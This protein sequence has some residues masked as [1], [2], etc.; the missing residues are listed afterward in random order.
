MEGLPEDERWVDPA[1]ELTSGQQSLLGEEQTTRERNYDSSGELG[2]APTFGSMDSTFDGLSAISDT[3]EENTIDVLTV[4]RRL[5]LLPALMEQNVKLRCLWEA[6]REKCKETEEKVVEGVLCQEESAKWERM[7]S[8]CLNFHK[9]KSLAELKGVIEREVAS[10]VDIKAAQL[11][12]GVDRISQEDRLVFETGHPYEEDSL[13]ILPLAS[14]LANSA[15]VNASIDKVNGVLRIQ[16]DPG[17]STKWIKSDPF[18]RYLVSELGEIVYYCMIDVLKDDTLNSVD[19]ALQECKSNL[20]KYVSR[21]ANQEASLK[22]YLE[23]V[24]VAYEST[25]KF[26][27]GILQ[28]GTIISDSF[29]VQEFST[30]MENILRQHLGFDVVRIEKKQPSNDSSMVVD[31]GSMFNDHRCLV[32]MPHTSGPMHS[33]EVDLAALVTRQSAQLISATCCAHNIKVQLDRKQSELELSLAD[34]EKQREDLVRAQSERRLEFSDMLLG[35][36][37]NCETLEDVEEFILSKGCIFF[38]GRIDIEFTEIQ[39]QTNDHVLPFPS[40]DRERYVVFKSKIPEDDDIHLVA[41]LCRAISCKLDLIGVSNNV[42][43]E[44][45]N[46]RAKYEEQIQ[47]SR[48]ISSNHVSGIKQLVKWKRLAKSLAGYTTDFAFSNVARLVSRTVVEYLVDFEKATTRVSLYILDVESKAVRIYCPDVFTGIEQQPLGVGL[49]GRVISSGVSAYMN[50]I[51]MIRKN[52]VLTPYDIEGVRVI[53]CVPVVTLEDFNNVDTFGAVEGVAR[54]VRGCIYVSSSNPDVCLEEDSIDALQLVAHHVAITLAYCEESSKIIAARDAEKQLL[55]SFEART[56]SM[57]GLVYQLAFADSIAAAKDIMVGSKIFQVRIEERNP[58]VDTDGWI[59]VANTCKLVLFRCTDP[60]VLDE[61]L[62]LISQVLS[63]ILRR[64]EFQDK[65]RASQTLLEGMTGMENTLKRSIGDWQHKHKLWQAAQRASKTILTTNQ[66]TD[67]FGSIFERTFDNVR[68]VYEKEVSRRLGD[69]FTDRQTVNKP[70]FAAT[71]INEE[72]VLVVETTQDGCVFNASEVELFEE[73]ALYL[74]KVLD[75]RKLFL[76]K[77]A[78]IRELGDAL[79]DDVRHRVRLGVDNF[80]FELISK[81]GVDGFQGNKISSAM[82]AQFS[83]MLHSCIYVSSKAQ[84]DDGIYVDIAGTDGGLLFRPKDD[85]FEKHVLEFIKP[86]LAVLF[87]INSLWVSLSSE[88][89]ERDLS[90]KQ[91]TSLVAQ[92]ELTMEEF[93]CDLENMSKIN[94]RLSSFFSGTKEELLVKSANTAA[95]I[96]NA[97]SAT[98]V[99][100]GHVPHQSLARVQEPIEQGLE[101]TLCSIFP[102]IRVRSALIVPILENDDELAGVLCVVNKR[103]AQG[104]DKRDESLCTELVVHFSGLWVATTLLD[105]EYTKTK[106]LNAKLVETK[107]KMEHFDATVEL[108]EDEQK[109][110]GLITAAVLDLL[111]VSSIDELFGVVKRPAFVGSL[112]AKHCHLY[113]AQQPDTLWTKGGEQL[114]FGGQSLVGTCAQRRDL[115]VIPD[116]RQY[117]LPKVDFIGMEDDPPRTVICC[118]ILASKERVVGVVI[119]L[120]VSQSIINSSSKISQT[121]RCLCDGLKAALSSLEEKHTLENSKLSHTAALTKLRSDL[122]TKTVALAAIE[123]ERNVAITRSTWERQCLQTLSSVLEVGL[124]ESKG[125]STHRVCPEIVSCAQRALGIPC[126]SLYILEQSVT[127]RFTSEG[128]PPIS[129]PLESEGIVYFF[130]KNEELERTIVCENL[131]SDCKYYKRGF[132]I[133][134]DASYASVFTAIKLGNGKTIGVLY[135]GRPDRAFSSDEVER[136]TLLTTLFSFALRMTWERDTNRHVVSAAGI[137]IKEYEQKHRALRDR[138]EGCSTQLDMMAKASR[139]QKDKFALLNDFFSIAFRQGV[140]GI[141][142]VGV[143]ERAIKMLDGIQPQL[144]LFCVGGMGK[145]YTGENKVPPCNIVSYVASTGQLFCSKFRLVLPI[146]CGDQRICGVLDLHAPGGD[147]ENQT[148]KQQ[149][150]MDD[151]RRMFSLAMECAQRVDTLHETITSVVEEKEQ[152]D[153][154]RRKAQDE[155]GQC[156]EN[157]NKLRQEMKA[158]YLSVLQ[159]LGVICES[160]TSKC[161]LIRTIEAQMATLVDDEV[162]FIAIEDTRAMYNESVVPVCAGGSSPETLG[163]L[164]LPKHVERFDVIQPVVGLIG[165]LLSMVTVRERNQQLIGELESECFKLKTANTGLQEEVANGNIENSRAR[166]LGDLLLRLSNRT[167]VGMLADTISAHAL[168]VFGVNSTR[169][170]AEFIHVE[171]SDGLTGLVARSRQLLSVRDATRDPRYHPEVDLKLIQGTPGKGFM[172]APVPARERDK[173]HGVVR[174]WVVGEQDWT[175]ADEQ[176]LEI[177]CNVTGNCVSDLLRPEDLHVSALENEEKIPY[178]SMYQTQVLVSEFSLFALSS[179]DKFEAVGEKLSLTARALLKAELVVSV[180]VSTENK[181]WTVQGGR[182]VH[183]DV[184]PGIQSVLLSGEPLVVPYQ[185]GRFPLERSSNL[186]YAS[187]HSYACIPCFGSKPS[188]VLGIIQVEKDDFSSDDIN[189]LRQLAGHVGMYLERYLH[190]GKT[191]SRCGELER[192]LEASKRS[193]AELHL[194]KKLPDE[195]TKEISKLKRLVV[196]K[197]REIDHLQD[198]VK[199]SEAHTREIETNA[200][201]VLQSARQ[202]QE[203]F[204]QRESKLVLEHKLVE[205]TLVE[206]SRR[207]LEAQER[208]YKHR[209]EEDKKSAQLLKE[210]LARA[211][212][213]KE[214]ILARAEHETSRLTEEKEALRRSVEYLQGER[215][216]G[217]IGKKEINGQL[218]ERRYKHEISRL[219]EEKEE[220]RRRVEYLQGSR[221]EEELFE[222]ATLSQSEFALA[223]SKR[224]HTHEISR[225]TKEKER[226]EGELSRDERENAVLSEKVEGLQDELTRA[227]LEIR[228]LT[229]EKER[230][231]HDKEELRRRVEYLQGEREFVDVGRNDELVEGRYKDEISRLTEEKEELRRRVEYLQGSRLEEELVENAILS[232]SEFALAESKRSLERRYKHEV[233]RLTKEKERDKEE[234]NRRVQVLEGELSRAAQD[235]EELRRRVEYLQESDEKD[236]Y[237]HEISSLTKEKER[238]LSRRV[239]VLEGELSRAAQD[240]EELRRRVEYLQESDAKEVLSQSAFALAESKR[241]HE[242]EIS[243]LTKEKERDKEELSR[244]VQVLEGELSRAKEELSDEKGI[245]ENDELTKRRLKKERDKEE[246]TRRVQV[247]EGELSRAGDDK[248]E[249]TR[250]VQVLEGELSRAGGDK[251]E[252]S[253]RVQILEGKLSRAKE[254]VL[255]LEGEL[256]RAGDDKAETSRRVQILEGELSRAKEDVLVLEGE[257]SR[258]GDDKEELSRRVQDLEGEL[259]R[260]KEELS[261]EKE[262]LD[263]E[264]AKRRCKSR[265]TE[266]KELDLSRVCSELRLSQVKRRAA[267][268][269][270]IKLEKQE[271]QERPGMV[272]GTVSGTPWSTVE[273]ASDHFHNDATQ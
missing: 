174:I 246:L 161:E 27:C 63:L 230:T 54:G 264:F 13:I 18:I 138:I 38:G 51:E 102:G 173:V 29:I 202:A 21:L 254:D 156:T 149:E 124:S 30:L 85:V 201:N 50:D 120:D 81:E 194:H 172:C 122:D 242:H 186:K 265:L 107:T 72:S 187:I 39:P 25:R 1:T 45:A 224:R 191:I 109:R 244:R 89:D 272:L 93:K 7:L 253:R 6:E 236:G 82:T 20:E 143:A 37:E 185:P 76:G 213:D 200:M 32:L 129:K 123:K 203:Q 193:C 146:V 215:V 192:E 157:E 151:L 3:E 207:A 239:Q 226:V 243:R 214:E 26:L 95:E 238:E 113:L 234:L 44:L 248:E 34:A 88:L 249:L 12:V 153:V 256:S 87:Q 255:V 218:V 64:T 65:L 144:H 177:L 78:K 73:L 154:F 94:S 223:E 141:L 119:F 121:L 126:I 61:E 220:L 266:E 128:H 163:F 71:L 33:V 159:G 104:F 221:L 229:G 180:L 46:L 132:D 262:I 74:D 69:I 133:E 99:L 217:D 70:G 4:Q 112:G 114:V 14:N 68:V 211:A 8:L 52:K 165:G 158:T 91:V 168:Q 134:L 75:L 175:R 11:L 79:A 47:A 108:L 268:K 209:L 135:F 42:S 166:K 96:V 162:K 241:R 105:N 115:I 169:G 58:S 23:L 261:D 40:L 270:L 53:G 164:R 86:R 110:R 258:A 36:E 101:R 77:E 269:K 257:L 199:S 204:K 259:S 67:C 111:K 148:P 237:K 22:E 212:Q 130:S 60:G 140:E 184:A 117:G 35:L 271:I 152:I 252:L 97:D 142:K 235:K 181:L 267:L 57:R 206:E 92:Q 208:Q 245:L 195:K 198:R 182:R 59:C 83:D 155:L 17:K 43:E 24:S 80:L 127:R 210:E 250:R 9:Q 84:L 41:V 136:I 16:L 48:E 103:D 216:G 273:R 147:F 137:R 251:A 171:D 10:L 176:N 49:A 190:I 19:K 98:I 228:R 106:M 118:P 125:L 2:F 145:I 167:S 62:D 183:V 189:H 31:L 205:N 131:L 116:N 66:L 170:L 55:M 179:L 247:L 15:F 100:G 231:A 150:D 28:E 222:G 219:T 178:E 240:K 260:S 225:L 233:S 197:E 160:A 263:D 90:L 188:I 5:D 232:Q 139:L 227:R 196:I 56:K